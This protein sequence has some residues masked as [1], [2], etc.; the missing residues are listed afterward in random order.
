MTEKS[1]EVNH[2]NVNERLALINVLLE[3]MH[4]GIKWLCMAIKKTW[5]NSNTNGSIFI[6]YI[7]LV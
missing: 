7:S 3:Y 5:P 2:G 1:I 6:Y 4:K